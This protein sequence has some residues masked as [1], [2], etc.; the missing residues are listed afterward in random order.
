MADQTVHY[1]DDDHGAKNITTTG[2]ITSGS[3]KGGV[4]TVVDT[5]TIAVTDETIICNKTTAFT[6]TL[7]VGV[8]GQK[9]TIKNIGV[10]TVTI[11]GDGADTIDGSLNQSLIQWETFTVQCYVANKWGVE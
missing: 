4:R 5:A 2:T 9:F 8:V 10:G 3:R 7:P 11:E 6:V 1:Q